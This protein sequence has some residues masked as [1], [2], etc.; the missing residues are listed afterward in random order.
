M[1]DI[2]D[3]HGNENALDGFISIV[4]APKHMSSLS[5]IPMSALNSHVSTESQNGDILR[6]VNWVRGLSRS[7]RVF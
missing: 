4:K 7:G 2:H 5:S 6:L 1:D 3:V